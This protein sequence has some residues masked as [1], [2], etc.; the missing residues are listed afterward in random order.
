MHQ[1]SGE[2][3][4]FGFGIVRGVITTPEQRTAAAMQAEGRLAIAGTGAAVRKAR[5]N[6]PD[7]ELQDIVASVTSDRLITSVM[8]PQVVKS[9]EDALDGHESATIIDSSEVPPAAEAIM[10]PLDPRTKHYAYT[11]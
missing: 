2:N 10:A 1:S 8:V 5:E 7:R 4:K 11:E 6:R 9:R 3:G